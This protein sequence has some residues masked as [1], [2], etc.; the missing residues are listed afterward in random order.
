LTTP[1]VAV[2]LFGD[3]RQPRPLAGL[4]VVRVAGPDDIDAAAGRCGRLLVVGADA[5]LGAVL[6]R[7]MRTDR[8][9]VEVGHVT[10]WRSARRARHGSVQRVPLIRDDAGQVIVR[11]AE[12]R[13]EDGAP[14]HGEAVVDDTQLFDGDVVGIR[15]EPTSAMPGLRATVLGSRRRRWVVGRAAQLGTTGAI[16]VRDGEAGRKTVRR[17]TFYRHTQGWLLVR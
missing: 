16:V 12:W 13:G 15:I 8:L 14:L 7:L 6:T 17:S 10:S 9:D 11:C 5:D 3:R 2:L 1:D 4:D